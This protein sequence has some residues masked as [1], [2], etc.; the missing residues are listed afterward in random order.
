MAGKT[1]EGAHRTRYLLGE[2][3]DPERERIEAEFFA[4][5]DAFQEM[6]VAE[7]DLIDDYARGE[8]SADER[9]QFER[10]FLTSSEGRERVHFARSF[11]AASGPRPVSLAADEPSTDVSPGFFA[12]IFGRAGVLQAALATTVVASLVGFSGLLVERSRVNR[13]LNE[14]RAERTSL[15]QRV[16]ELQQTADAERLRNEETMAQLNDLRQRLGNESPPPSKAAPQSEAPRRPSVEPGNNETFA[17]NRSNSPPVQ[18][19]VTFDLVPGSV[20]SGPGADLAVPAGAAYIKLR[21]DLDV[22]SP[23]QKYRAEIESPEGRKIWNSNVFSANR[24]ASGD[25]IGELRLPVRSLPP[26]H[27][28][29]FLQAERANGVFEQVAYYSFRVARK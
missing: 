14:L 4:D 18:E 13:E 15:N 8:L 10:R 28:V 24:S 11:A 20:R 5:D 29:M 16:Q 25:F 19:S 23:D 6:L 22:G 1:Q 17:N 9:E 26:G 21:F 3:S 7:D 2:A 12:L 27:Y